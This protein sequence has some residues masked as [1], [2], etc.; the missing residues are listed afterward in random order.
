MAAIP[1]VSYDAENCQISC[2]YGGFRGKGNGVVP[3]ADYGHR[4]EEP[5]WEGLRRYPSQR[6]THRHPPLN[7]L[8]NP[9]G[10]AGLRGSEWDPATAAVAAGDRGLNGLKKGVRVT[11]ED[12]AFDWR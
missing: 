7:S 8:R 12:G 2:E 5:D 3:D 1:A 10:L 4:S 9:L 11:E 6:G